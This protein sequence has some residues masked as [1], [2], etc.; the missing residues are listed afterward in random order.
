[1]ECAALCFVIIDCC[2]CIDKKYV[3][4]S[5]PDIKYNFSNTMIF[6]NVYYVDVLY[7]VY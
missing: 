2:R 7:D 1:M 3:K 5:V 4:T 6:V